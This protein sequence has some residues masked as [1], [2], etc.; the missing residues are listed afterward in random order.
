MVVA[1][2]QLRLL[3]QT[4]APDMRDSSSRKYA[5]IEDPLCHEVR[6]IYVGWGVLQMRCICGIISIIRNIIY[7][8]T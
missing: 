8:K 5:E 7:K 3:N 6:E 4:F 2:V 1:T